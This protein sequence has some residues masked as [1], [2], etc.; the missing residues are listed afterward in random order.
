MGSWHGTAPFGQTP[1]PGA[2]PWTNEGPAAAR[3][4]QAGEGIRNQLRQKPFRTS[5]PRSTLYDG[6]NVTIEIRVKFPRVYTTLPI[7]TTSTHSR[8]LPESLG[9]AIA[10]NAGFLRPACA[11]LPIVHIIP[12]VP[13]IGDTIPAP[14]QAYTSGEDSL[15]FVQS[16]LEIM[17]AATTVILN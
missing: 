10:Y 2:P 16:S 3:T 5:T 4:L 12:C 6:P 13:T 14:Q 1:P 11:R 9:F 15:L 7:P 17:T 8:S